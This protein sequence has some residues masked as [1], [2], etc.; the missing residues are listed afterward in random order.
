MIELYILPWLYV[1]CIFLVCFFSTCWAQIPGIAYWN[2]PLVRWSYPGKPVTVDWPLR[3]HQKYVKLVIE[4]KNRLTKPSLFLLIYE[5]RHDKTNIMGLGPAWIQ[6]SLGIHPVWS[7]SMLFAISFSTCYRVCKQTAWILIGL[8]RCA[9][10]SG[11]MLVANALCWFCHGAPH[12]LN[13]NNKK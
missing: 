12:F 5:P 6:T 8:R 7:G 3:C 11:S 13:K 4:K 2:K 1:P 9:G 10:W